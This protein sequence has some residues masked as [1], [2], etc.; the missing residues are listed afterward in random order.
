[1]KLV[2]G[3]IIAGSITAIAILGTSIAPAAAVE[4]APP[5]SF[6]DGVRLT[7][8]NKTIDTL[9][10]DHETPIKPGEEASVQSEAAWE[11]TTDKVVLTTDQDQD[12]K[13][14]AMFTTYGSNTTFTSPHTVVDIDSASGHKYGSEYQMEGD[15]DVLVADWDGYKVTSKRHEDVNDVKQFTVTIEGGKQYISPKVTAE[16][17]SSK[18][19]YFNFDKKLVPVAKNGGTANLF[20]LNQG[21]RKDVHVRWND[22]E[23]PLTTTCA[24]GQVKF[25]SPGRAPESVEVG[26]STRFRFFTITNVGGGGIQ[27]NYKFTFADR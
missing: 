22:Q 6:A 19:G 4:P 9:Y 3:S 16:N 14:G 10:R 27:G 1:M 12:K 25:S 18:N 13:T 24:D 8:L 7:V 2:V 20:T 15:F 21:T 11:S 26:K 17:K 23:L 5:T